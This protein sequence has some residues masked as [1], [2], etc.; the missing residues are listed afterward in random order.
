MRQN[1]PF[2]QKIETESALLLRQI[3]ANVKEA[4]KGGDG[5]AI[6]KYPFR[7]GEEISRDVY[8]RLPKYLFEYESLS[9][10]S[11]EAKVLYAKFLELMELSA[12]YGWYD[13]EG[14]LYIRYTLKNVEDFFKCSNHKA[15]EIFK[16]LGEDGVGLIT[17][18]ELV[19][20]RPSVIYV[21]KFIREEDDLREEYR[22]TYAQKNSV[23]A[24]KNIGYA[25]K[26]YEHTPER[27]TNKYINKNIIEKNS[28]K[29]FQKENPYNYSISDY[30]EKYSEKGGSL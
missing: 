13:E 22:K 20:G 18:V 3:F 9:G 14:R 27:T 12:K 5:V 17:R 4:E 25:Q 10:L 21:H 30:E 28:Y 2:F 16:E 11:V 1:R 7:R 19:K 6:E 24:Q 26:N 15:R 23:C 8:Y 29:G